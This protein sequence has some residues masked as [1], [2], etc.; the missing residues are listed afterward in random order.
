M[1]LPQTIDL[2]SGNWEVGLYSI[3]YPNTWYILQRKGTTVY[4]A[5]GGL[6]V[7]QQTDIPYGYYETVQ[8]VVDAINTP[9]RS[10]GSLESTIKLSFNKVTGKVHV[11]ISRE[12]MYF[13][14]RLSHVLGF[15][16][17]R[18]VIKR[19]SEGPHVADLPPLS[20]IYV[21]CDIVQ[22]QIVGDTC[23]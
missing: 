2:G 15:G 10:K 14:E 22:S 13:D 18:V 20:T 23:A 1:Q 4:Y 21:Y 8:Q 5:T 6:T 12:N 9:L 7:W 16:A 3:S 17:K 11:E 19:T